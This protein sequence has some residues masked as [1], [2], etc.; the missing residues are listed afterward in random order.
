MTWALAAVGAGACVGF[1]MLV[2]AVRNSLRSDRSRA[3]LGAALRCSLR[4][5][6]WPYDPEHYA[7]CPSCL[8]PTSPVA[9]DGAQPLEPLEARSIRL[10]HE[11]ERFYAA[12]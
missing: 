5:I 9:D 3:V 10:H 8:E 1:A 2:I 4:G 11:F 7:Q 6:D 12:R